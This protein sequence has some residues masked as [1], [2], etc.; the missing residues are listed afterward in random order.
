MCI[1]YEG[2]GYVYLSITP[3]SMIDP[4][5]FLV[6][7]DHK[8]IS[9]SQITPIIPYEEFARQTLG[10]TICDVETKVFDLTKTIFW[11]SFKVECEG[12]CLT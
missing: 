6:T 3:Y 7:D 10:L 1:E 2:Y 4:S 11:L 5:M 12:E 9:A 8:Q